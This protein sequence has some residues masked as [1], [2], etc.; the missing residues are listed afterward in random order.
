M[1]GVRQKLPVA[2]AGRQRARL[3][4]RVEPSPRP[5]GWRPPAPPKGIGPEARRAWR[6]FWASDAALAVDERSDLPLLREWAAALDELHAVRA[7][8]RAGEGDARALAARERSLARLVLE[9]SD[10]FGM[11]PLARFR[12]QL[13]SA[14]AQRSVRA[15]AR[16]L[17]EEHEVID[18]E[19]LDG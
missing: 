15:L 13:T 6:R 14:E 7:Q 11:H 16:E 8:L 5:P 17:E 19:A 10:R 18:L 12:L 1:V 4:R 9:L 3:A 2:L